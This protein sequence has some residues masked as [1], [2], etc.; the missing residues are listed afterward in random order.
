MYCKNCGEEINDNVKFCGKCGASVQEAGAVTAV[1]QEETSMASVLITESKDTVVRFF[2]KNPSAVIEEAAQSKS[3]TGFMLIIIN[4]ILFAF[5][6]CFNIPQAG[7]YI[8]NAA[9]NA[10]QDMA[11]SISGSALGGSIAG[12]YLPTAAASPIFDMFIPLFFA[13]IIIFAVE[14]AGIYIALKAERTKLSH[15]A[16]AVNVMG[17]AALP[18][19]AALVLNFIIGF[20]YPLAV[21]FVYAAAVLVHM[22]LIY[23]GLRHMTNKD[24]AP[25][26]GVA[27]L[28]VIIAAAMLIAFTVAAGRIGDALQKSITDT[29]ADGIGSVLGSLF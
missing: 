18:L 1:R 5:V 15:Y 8:F 21:L 9:V 3:Y 23:D 16:N 24:E 22:A 29:I 19:S 14:F 28:S 27:V 13:A 7:V 12:S 10:I 26:F 4:A 17:A 6:S 2:T 11:S 20:I 25:V